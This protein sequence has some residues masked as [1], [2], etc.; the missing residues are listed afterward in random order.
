MEDVTTDLTEITKH[1]VKM[2]DYINSALLMT[3]F[4]SFAFWWLIRNFT[5]KQM[6]KKGVRGLGLLLYFTGI[7]SE[8]YCSWIMVFLSS[9]L[10]VDKSL[11]E[12][13]GRLRGTYTQRFGNVE[14]DLIATYNACLI[15]SQV[16]NISTLFLMI[17]SWMPIS[18]GEAYPERPFLLS[19]KKSN[20][21]ALKRLSNASLQTFAT[22]YVFVRIPLEILF[23][24]YQVNLTQSTIIFARS[25]FFG[26][27]LVTCAFLLLILK[28]KYQG[29]QA[30]E[31]EV[32]LRNNGGI[33]ILI[34]ILLMDSLFNH[35][36]NVLSIPLVLNEVSGYVMEKIGFLAH[37]MVSTIMLA[38]L[39]PL[40]SVKLH[41]KKYDEPATSDV[42]ADRGDSIFVDKNRH[43]ESDDHV[44]IM[45]R[46][47]G[48]TN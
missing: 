37:L 8:L 32:V 44:D 29:I 42:Y 20:S 27:E 35:I 40:K 30:S 33:N 11:A 18:F 7:I 17:A 1:S 36:I 10:D 28:I 41:R 3:V 21:D 9:K 43:L 14:I 31:R 48:S 38:V 2:L 6:P 24:K 46:K 22:S 12:K 16:L 13:L 19:K 39:C 34:V 4:V 26:L 25:V 23:S 47:I 5:M 45:G 15:A